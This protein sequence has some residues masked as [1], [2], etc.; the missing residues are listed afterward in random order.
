MY[1]INIFMNQ[2]LLEYYF[3]EE[4][5]LQNL[6]L[7]MD[8]FIKF[9]EKRGINISKEL[10]DLEKNNLFYPMFGIEKSRTPIHILQAISPHF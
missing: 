5:Y 10:E 8:K 7:K 1:D 4:V 6:P 9:C 3:E 2:E